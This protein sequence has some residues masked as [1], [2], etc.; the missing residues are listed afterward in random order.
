MDLHYILF[1]CSVSIKRLRQAL[2]RVL[3]KHAALRTSFHFDT[4][5]NK[6]FQRIEPLADDYEGFTFAL[7]EGVD[8]YDEINRL[9]MEEFS[10]Q[11]LF[12]TERGQLVRLHIVRRTKMTPINEDFVKVG[13]I[14]IFT[15]RHEAIDGTS[16]GLFL[17]DLTQSYDT[18]EL[19]VDPNAISYL[20][21]TLYQ[22]RIDRSAS[23][24]Y[25]IKYVDGADLAVSRLI[26]R[27]PSDRPWLLNS[28][29]ITT[30]IPVS[31]HLNDKIASAMVECAR[32][33]NVTI[34]N[35]CLACHFAF[36]IELT[37]EWDLLVDCNAAKRP[38]EPEAANI[39]GPFTDY[40][41]CRVNLDK[42][43][44]PTFQ[45]LLEKTHSTMMESLD[46]LFAE[47]DPLSRNDTE[48]LAPDRQC[49]DFQFDEMLEDV[50]LD[51]NV[52][53]HHVVNPSDN[54]PAAIWWRVAT[55]THFGVYVIYDSHRAKLSYAFVFST[56]TYE[57]STAVRIITHEI[58]G[59]SDPDYRIRRARYPFR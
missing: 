39:L 30:A 26:S 23:I 14:I 59:G 25:W 31:F 47:E 15:I 19:V 12:D 51:N 45:S 32:E 18:G 9:I 28:Y 13:D 29:K 27:I 53:L 52:R 38:L 37:D 50:V 2:R 8:S 49:S 16:V 57:R 35:L 46:H 6:W 4:L 44:N 5:A 11:G 40:I 34:A 20:D 41:I 36:L 10:I 55:D 7:S 54:M 33:N 58:Q 43:T 3:V 22:S 48:M 56:A 24:S 42:K 17:S 1:N 21:Y